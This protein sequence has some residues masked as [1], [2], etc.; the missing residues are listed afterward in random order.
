MRAAAPGAFPP[1]LSGRRPAAPQSPEEGAQRAPPLGNSGSEK[2][3]V[4]GRNATGRVSPKSERN[5]ENEGYF[6]GVG[7][8][9]VLA[10]GTATRLLEVRKRLTK[11][12]VCA[13][14]REQNIWS[15]RVAW[16]EPRD[17]LAP[18]DRPHIFLDNS[19]KKNPFSSCVSFI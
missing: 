15:E 3:K 14:N 5:A 2:R 6:C 9:N 8:R 11:G 17:I 18:V 13:E 4:Q 19:H 12:L 7:E 1:F 10:K 16:A